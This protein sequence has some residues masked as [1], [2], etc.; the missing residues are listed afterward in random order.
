MITHPQ[1]F[2]YFCLS[3]ISG[4]FIGSFFYSNYIIYFLIIVSISLI[5]ILWKKKH[6]LMVVFLILI[7]ILG[8]FHINLKKNNILENSIT[9]YFNSEI[10]ARGKVVRYPKDDLET[11][12]AVIRIDTV[13]EE[14]NNSCI[15]IYTNQDLSVNDE[16][17]IKGKLEEPENF[18]NFNY[19][20][21]LANQG[22][23]GIIKKPQIEI[24][25]ENH[26]FIFDFKKKVEEIVLKNLSISKAGMLN[27]TIL[28]ETDNMN[29]D[30][31]QKLGFTGISHVIAISGQHIVLLC[32]V[33]L[34]FL[35]F[36]KMERKKSII[37]TFLFIFFYIILIDF[38][39][40]ALRAFIMM[41]FVLFAELFGR[42]SDVLRSLIIAAFLILV[43]NP[44]AL[45]YDL[46]FQLSFFAVLGII[47]FNSYFKNKLRFIKNNF[48]NDLISVNLSAQVFVLPLFIYTFKYISLSSFITNSLVVPISTV[49]L[50][51][52]FLCVVLSLILPSFS[53]FFFAPI[54]LILGYIIFIID[55]FSFMIIEINN[56]PLIFLF[57][58]YLILIFLAYRLRKNRF[59]FYF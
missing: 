33:M 29:S 26:F 58:I 35:S 11:K 47:F 12:K 13:N 1:A 32:V 50:I 46:G 14:K 49:L 52:G 3:F 40:S 17:V 30:L 16:I 10:V 42:Q 20:M 39:A 54:S 51:L 45:V 41:S 6:V 15:L 55:M 18:S 4:I 19:K 8:Y 56:F 2:I 36:V 7:F 5:G 9:K 25:S 59:E 38:P 31:K 57:V 27:A 23:S 44:L 21:Y 28:G 34:S 22:I 37:L 24:I 53:F 43:F 48:I